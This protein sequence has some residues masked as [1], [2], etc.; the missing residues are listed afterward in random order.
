M[1]LV[2]LAAL[3]AVSDVSAKQGESKGVRA[4]V[5]YLGKRYPEP[6]PLSLVDPILKDKGIQGARLGH[7]NNVGTA[8]ILGHHYE[9]DEVILPADGDVVAAAKKLLDEGRRFFVADL[10]P[11]D[12]L[13]VSALPEAKDALIVNIRA[14]DDRL[15]NEY[16]RGNLFH[17]PPSLAMRADA[18]AQYFAWKKWR[19]LLLVKGTASK[20]EEFIKAMR[21]AAKRFGLKIVD[22]RQNTFRAG[23][24]R[25]DDGHQQI[26]S[27]I[28]RL[29]QRAPEHDVVVVADTSEMFGE[30]MLFRTA[31]PR[32]VSGTHG[33]VPVAWHVA[34]EQ[35]GGTQMQSRFERLA[36]RKMTE[37]DYFGWLGLRVFGEALMRS[38]SANPKVVRDYILSDAFV[39]AAFKGRGLTFRKWNQQLRQPVLLMAARSLISISPQPGFLHP[40]HLTDTLGFDAPESGCRFPS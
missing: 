7:K 35:Y 4:N 12:L 26:Q 13:A 10:E 31:V 15:R 17:V 1:S 5:V 25:A 11:D 28:P 32:A 3:F 36:G 23:H 14:S 16:C 30:F 8:R 20:D 37:R 33:L 6:L 9:L 22:E 24:R 21:R 38:G 29:T 18:L 2:L 34:F 27:R 19:R 39:L 40:K